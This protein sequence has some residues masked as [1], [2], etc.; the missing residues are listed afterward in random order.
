MF[1]DNEPDQKRMEAFLTDEDR[2]LLTDPN[3][4][5]A[6]KAEIFERLNAFQTA[7][8]ANA[9]AEDMAK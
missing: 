2:A 8:L 7:D 1:P 4:P 5:A 3:V 9:G 6:V